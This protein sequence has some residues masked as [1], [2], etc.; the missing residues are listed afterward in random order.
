MFDGRDL[1]EAERWIDEWR[2]AIDERADR[3]RILSVRLARLSETARSPDGLVTVTVGAGGDM[4][5]LDLGEGIRRR[6]AGDTARE[7]MATL[8]AARSRLLTAVTAVTHETVG[9]DSA[10]GRAVVEAFTA[11]VNRTD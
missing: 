10:T 5:A 7:I 3:A 1:H 6:P 4:T 11:G 2:C 9:A 8:R